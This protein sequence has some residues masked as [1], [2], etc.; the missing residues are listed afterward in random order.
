MER[1]F[2]L[3]MTNESTHALGVP[4]PRREESLYPMGRGECPYPRW[5]RESLSVGERRMSLSQ[6]ES[7]PVPRGDCP[8]PQMRVSLSKEERSGSLSQEE[9]VPIHKERRGSLSQE[10]KRLLNHLGEESRLPCTTHG[11]EGSQVYL[12]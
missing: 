4:V 9:R 8:Y 6:E 3:T 5:R 1:G 7:V 2:H 11:E 10:E 12:S